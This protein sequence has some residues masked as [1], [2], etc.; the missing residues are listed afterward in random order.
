MTFPFPMVVPRT[1]ADGSVGL[2]DGLSPTA[3][4]SFSRDLLTSFVGGSRYTLVSGNVDVLA[5]QS[6]NSRNMSAPG[7]ANRPSLTTAGPN[8]KTCGD[9]D[10]SNDVLQGA[11]VSNFI[12]N[13]A[14]YMIASFNL[15]TIT[16]DGGSNTYN[17]HTILADQGSFMGIYVRNSDTTPGNPDT[18]YAFNW[19][20]N[21]D[22]PGIVGV[23]AGTTYVAEWK[24]EAGSLS[25]RLNGG[26]WTSAASG[27][28][29][30]VTNNLS[31]G[32]KAGG[33]RPA[34]G[35]I[36]EAATWSTVPSTLVQDA[37]AA[38]FK[39]WIGA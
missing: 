16:L 9:W 11:A 1:V 36:F 24:H 33:V 14:G 2:L 4:W 15:D 7:S 34:D 31:I 29:T 32:G 21:D 3:A 5:D 39:S 28:T 25:V 22:H 27:N 10:G 38:S 18:V 26:S 12:A 35:K 20:G 6:G 8:S 30:N 37:V 17:N 13:S 23:I 19:D